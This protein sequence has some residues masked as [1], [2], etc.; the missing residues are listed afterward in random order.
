[1]M[2]RIVEL[3]YDSGKNIKV[4]LQLGLSIYGFWNLDF[5]RVINIKTCLRLNFLTII[6]MDYLSGIYPLFLI[7]LT[8]F[9]VQLYEL[10]FKPVNL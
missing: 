1:M 2:C 10:K 8:Y 6:L 5:F 3:T 4:P 9:A 7:M